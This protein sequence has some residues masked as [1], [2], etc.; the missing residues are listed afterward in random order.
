MF[1]QPSRVLIVEKERSLR[2]MLHKSLIVGEFAVEEACNNKEALGMAQHE[3][4]DLVLLDMESP[5]SLDS[6]RRLRHMSPTTSI[7]VII[8]ERDLQGDKVQALEAGADDYVT[9]PFWLSELM[10]RLRSVLR[11]RALQATAQPRVCTAPAVVRAGSLAMDLSRRIVWHA[12]TEVHLSPKQ[13]SLLAFMIQNQGA[14][15]SHVQLLR[16]VWGPEYGNEVEYLRSYIY[17]LRKKIEANPT[18]PDYILT[19]PWIGYRFAIPVAER[20]ANDAC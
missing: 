19:E 1:S 14:P 15:L 11:R 3:P 8:R 7:L 4:F 9:K 6:C 17:A 5:A 16:S 18:E 20:V 12:G 10:A 13:F 2:K